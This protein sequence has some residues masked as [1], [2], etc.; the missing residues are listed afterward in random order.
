[1]LA[2]LV[3]LADLDTENFC[4]SY[5]VKAAQKGISVASGALPRHISLGSPHPVENFEEYLH[6][7][8]E[9]ATV[10]SPLKVILTGMEACR[11]KT[12]NR[13]VCWLGFH[14]LDNLQLEQARVQAARWLAG[15]EIYLP[16][17]DPVRGTRNLTLLIGEEDLGACQ[18]Y[19]R[20]VSA[21]ATGRTAVFDQM[22]VFLYDGDTYGECDYFCCRRF[23]L[24]TRKEGSQQKLGGMYHVLR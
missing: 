10:L 4:G 18:S 19:A 9:F 5:T 12:G 15:Q 7:A 3:Y 6:M 20:E 14:Y 16:E 24:R 13:E 11:A 17:P 1:M 23:R 8:E 22:G 2:A 21:T